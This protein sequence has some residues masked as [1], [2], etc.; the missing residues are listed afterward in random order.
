MGANFH[1]L[2]L[3]YEVWWSRGNVLTHLCDLREEVLLF[4]ADINPPPVRRM[5]DM[6]W[7]EMLAYL[8]DIFNGI[9]TLNTSLQ[10]TECSVF[11]AHYHV[12]AFRKKLYLW[13]ARVE[14]GL[15]EMFSTLED[16]GRAGLHLDTVQ[17]VI[18]VHLKWLHEQIG[19]YFGEETLA[20]QC[21]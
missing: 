16:V 19:E 8:S 20:N 17:Q 14:Q 6:N 11:L 7:V 13:C 15:V 2:L 4:L 21:V 9:N 18:T 3:Q 1:Q 10:G 5:E 12:S